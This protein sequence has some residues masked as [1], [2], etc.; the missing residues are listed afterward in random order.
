MPDQDLVRKALLHAVCAMRGT[1]WTHTLGEGTGRP[2]EIVIDGRGRIPF[3]TPDISQD[4]SWQVA[5]TFAEGSP[6]ITKQSDFA[7]VK[8][9]SYENPRSGGGS[10]AWLLLILSVIYVFRCLKL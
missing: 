2:D 1:E 9:G 5:Q 10:I 6:N 3:S 7:T 4:S 8:V